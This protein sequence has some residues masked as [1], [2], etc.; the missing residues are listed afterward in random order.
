MTW[1]NDPLVLYHGTICDYADDIQTNGV[2]LS[3][4]HHANRRYRQQLGLFRRG[5]ATHPKHAAVI[6]FTID[7]NLPADTSILAFVGPTNDWVELVDHCLKGGVHKPRS[8]TYYDVVFGPLRDTRLTAL[9]RPYEQTSFHG[10]AILRMLILD[11]VFRGTP[12]L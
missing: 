12:H 1:S 7:R 2:S 5:K 8:N 4:C 9:P 6:K 10:T 3:K 11:D